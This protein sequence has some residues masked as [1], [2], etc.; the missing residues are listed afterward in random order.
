MQEIIIS[1]EYKNL[2]DTIKKLKDEV[3]ALYEEKHQ[4]IYHECK[5][6]EAE[7][8]SKVGVLEYK[9]YEFMCKVYRIKRKIELY[10]MYIN[11]QEKVDE[12]AVEAQLDDEYKEY[13]EKLKQMSEDLKIALDNASK[14]LLTREEAEELKRIY[15]KLI[16]KLHPDLNP[17]CTQEDLNL[18]I[19]VTKAYENG[20][21]QTL[22][23]FELL[24][25]EIS[26]KEELESE[27]EELKKQKLKYEEIIE[28]ILNDIE[29]IKS[30]FPYNKKEFIKDEKQIS[31]KK[32]MLNETLEYYKKIYN[33]MSEILSKMKGAQ[34]WVI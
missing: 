1:P 14:E 20:D 30:E 29:K 9:V 11:R 21:L 5:F 27:F 31:E 22:R 26:E 17:N 16:K 6:I 24:I 23:N 19:K 33:E 7:Y 4:L 28:K 32:D 18:L 25:Q 13:E 2:L 15:R 3:A 12:Q 34:R 10:Q 8:M